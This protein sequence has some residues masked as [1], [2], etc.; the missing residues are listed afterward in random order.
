[1]QS[2]SGIDILNPQQLLEEMT[3]FRILILIVALTQTPLL[4][5]GPKEDALA[6]FEKFFPAFVSGNQKEVADMFAPDAQF[7]GTLSR[8]L[9]TKPEGV[10]QYFTAALTNP[11]SPKAIPMMATASALSDSIV[12]I[13]GNWKIERNVNGSITTTGPYRTTAVMQKRGDRWLIVQF[14]NSPIPPAP[15]SVR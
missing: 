1:L 2:F 11:A 14:H 10:L 6:A 9:V 8:E 7:Y 3:M 4:H 15:T 12:Q 5:A 13:A